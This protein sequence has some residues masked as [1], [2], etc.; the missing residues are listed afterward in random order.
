MSHWKIY[1]VQTVIWRHTEVDL[2]FQNICCWCIVSGEKSVYV[3]IG[4][5][6]KKVWRTEF[7]D[8]SV[9]QYSQTAASPFSHSL[10]NNRVLSLSTG[11]CLFCSLSLFC[12]QDVHTH[13][14]KHMGK[15]KVNLLLLTRQKQTD[16]IH[17]D[18]L[19]EREWKDVFNSKMRLDI[20]F[21]QHKWC[22]DTVALVSNVSIYAKKKLHVWIFQCKFKQ[23][24]NL[25]FI[26]SSLRGSTFQLLSKDLS[27]TCSAGFPIIQ[28]SS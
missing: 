12:F 6:F 15:K 7:S 8:S 17:L 28:W 25:C 20:G 19:K 26:S 27:W 18:V 14:P 3:C 13:G 23:D 1:R 22:E 21:A 11:V 9:I 4:Q 16:W 2:Q 10:P 5:I 24:D